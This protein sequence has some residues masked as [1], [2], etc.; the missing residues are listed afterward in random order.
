MRNFKGLIMSEY[1]SKLTILRYFLKIFSMIHMP[2]KPIASAGCDI[3][4]FL[5]KKLTLQIKIYTQ[6]RVSCSIF[7]KFSGGNIYMPLN[8]KQL[9]TGLHA[10]HYF[11]SNEQC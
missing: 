6:T 3:T 4:L 2:Y 9:T 11:V 5:C 10:H 1:T 8:P 7:S